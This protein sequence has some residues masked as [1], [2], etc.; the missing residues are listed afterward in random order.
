M[1]RLQLSQTITA[2]ARSLSYMAEEV[3]ALSRS[4]HEVG[5]THMAKKLMHFSANLDILAHRLSEA[6]SEEAHEAFMNSQRNAYGILSTL[7]KV[8]N[9]TS[10]I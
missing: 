6:N 7:V 5:N 2:A 3:D 10:Q 8:S 9:E 1:D 4:F